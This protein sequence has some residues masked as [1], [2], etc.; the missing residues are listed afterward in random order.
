MYFPALVFLLA[1]FYNIMAVP[2]KQEWLSD[3]QNNNAI[4]VRVAEETQQ[5][6]G[7]GKQAKVETIISESSTVDVEDATNTTEIEGDDLQTMKQDMKLIMNMLKKHDDRLQ[8]LENQNEELK[9]ELNATNSKT[10]ANL[11]QSSNAK[12]QNTESQDANDNIQNG[13]DSGK[14]PK[15]NENNDQ[16]SKTTS[17]TSENGTETKTKNGFSSHEHDEHDDV[18]ESDTRRQQSKLVRN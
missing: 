4:I 2:T 7:E 15:T 1:G 11:C 6:N 12:A 13:V 8:D 14:H 10:K 17:I 9:A 3:P 5:A 18:W 16:P